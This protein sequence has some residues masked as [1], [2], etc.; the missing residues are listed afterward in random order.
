MSFSSSVHGS[1]PGW[2]GRPMVGVR[3]QFFR[4]HAAKAL[5]SALPFFV[6]CAGTWDTVTSRRFKDDPFHVMFHSDDPNQVLKSSEEAGMRAKAMLEIKEPKKAG[7]TEEEQF[8][9]LQILATSAT[10]DKHPQCRMNA[11]AALGRFE[12]P[13]TS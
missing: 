9:I 10:S 1:S 6:G 2:R 12:D 13:R 7:G 3:I 5:L 11:I 8:Q 4:R